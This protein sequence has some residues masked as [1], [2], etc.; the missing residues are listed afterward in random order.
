M[1]FLKFGYIV[2]N[3][4]FVKH[5]VHGIKVGVTTFVWCNGIGKGEYSFQNERFQ[6]A[7]CESTD[8]TRKYAQ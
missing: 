6:C 7:R 2:E 1:N 3:R 8:D 5:N 4:I